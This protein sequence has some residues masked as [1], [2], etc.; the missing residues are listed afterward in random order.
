MCTMITVETYMKIILESERIFDTFEAAMQKEVSQSGLK[1]EDIN[2]AIRQLQST[3][4]GLSP[5]K[6][7]FD[8]NYDSPSC[9]AA[10]LYLYAGCHASVVFAE[11]TFLLHLYPIQFAWLMRYD[12]SELHICSLGGGPGSDVVGLLHSRLHNRFHCR[13]ANTIKSIRCTIVDLCLGWNAALQHVRE[14]YLT[15]Y[16]GLG[17]NVHFEFRRADLCSNSLQVMEISTANIVCLVKYVSVT[18]FYYAKCPS[19]LE[20]IFWRMKPG[21]FVFFVD[22]SYG[23]F[24]EMTLR[25]A[26]RAGL[27]LVTPP[28]LHNWK[29]P[30]KNWKAASHSK[31]ASRSLRKTSVICAVWIKCR[32]TSLVSLPAIII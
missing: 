7:T 21:A 19:L 30:S 15:N 24:Y 1:T 31:F 2:Q 14:A 17:E 28:F 10:Y 20:I 3:Y 11:L 23:G 26:T 8:I 12:A 16:A 13:T 29:F 5:S 6:Q 22:N 4:R 9:R 27:L 18:S 32:V 25:A